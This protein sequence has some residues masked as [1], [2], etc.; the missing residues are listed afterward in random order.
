M[1]A[2]L[3]GPFWIFLI[4][5]IFGTVVLSPHLSPA[6]NL[7]MYERKIRFE[8]AIVDQIY[9]QL[10]GIIDRKLYKVTANI[11]LE[12]VQQPLARQ[13]Y[14][15]GNAGNNNRGKKVSDNLPGFELGDDTNTLKRETS[16]T[17]EEIDQLK[18]L[19]IQLYV[20]K[21][22]SAESITLA[23]TYIEDHWVKTKPEKI[24][25][26][27]ST[28]ELPQFQP[29]EEKKPEPEKIISEEKPEEKKDW[30]TYLQWWP[31]GLA[32][33][34]LIIIALLLRRKSSDNNVE[35]TIAR[36][37]SENLARPVPLTGN[38]PLTELKEAFIRELVSDPRIGRGFL[39]NLDNESKE[40]LLSYFQH[41][42][43]R[44]LLEK[45]MNY[46][47]A[48]SILNPREI[49][50]E[51]LAICLT[52]LKE[53][54]NLRHIHIQSPFGYLVDLDE[55]DLRD[56]LAQESVESLASLLPFVPES[57]RATVISHLSQNDQEKILSLVSTGDQPFKESGLV[58]L[59]T[60]LREKFETLAKTRPSHK[61][62]SD[63]VI[64]SVLEA[65]PESATLATRLIEKNP[66]AEITF[67]KYKL[68]LEDLL[69]MDVEK[70]RRAMT[71]LDN[72]TIIK[73]MHGLETPAREKVMHAMSSERSRIIKGLSK[74]LGSQFEDAEVA[75]A[76][77]LLHRALRNTD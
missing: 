42:Y 4:F 58:R 9:E 28:I 19:A 29:I 44:E 41:A 32:L 53:Y 46:S 12:R 43:T 69:A 62:S 22:L 1:K 7:S 56:L 67:G 26:T 75:S 61:V 63:D 49:R 38:Q 35:L 18:T 8:N 37:K 66:E 23:K 51:R 76:K 55:V 31:L 65:S 33:L 14:Q 71:N 40:D 10:D 45:W 64:R 5:V 68:T 30:R 21:T 11:E 39:E 34:S 52:E 27:V 57:K 3:S 47:V 2:K 60:R 16:T 74:S 50:P 17:Y 72:E 36:Q 13:V 70:T 48:T 20:D 25:L 77:K 73:A 59:D 6:Q 15:S 24:T 54:K